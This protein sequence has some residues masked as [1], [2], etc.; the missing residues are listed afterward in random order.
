M[1]L[2]SLWDHTQHLHVLYNVAD[3]RILR[4]SASIRSAFGDCIKTISDLVY[5]DDLLISIAAAKNGVVLP[6]R[7]RLGAGALRWYN[8]SGAVL[9]AGR[10][11]LL[12]AQSITDV[13]RS[14]ESLLCQLNVGTIRTM[15]A[16]DG[17]LIIDASAKWC[18]LTGYSRA[19]VIG[20]RGGQKL[21]YGPHTSASTVLRIRGRIANQLDVDVEAIVSCKDRSTFL[22]RITW[23]PLPNGECCGSISAC[24][25]CVAFRPP[26][27]W[28]VLL[29]DDDLVCRYMW[30]RTMYVIGPDW[31][32]DVA[33]TLEHAT[34]YDL[35]VVRK[36]ILNRNNCGAG[37][38][39]RYSPRAAGA[40][41]LV[42]ISSQPLRVGGNGGRMLSLHRV[43]PKPEA[44]A[45]LLGLEDPTERIKL[46]RQP[47]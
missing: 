43:P 18:D 30:Q 45:I 33:V 41:F 6:H 47:N 14:W 24:S 5:P 37:T 4:R 9:E 3:G 26:R 35:V 12:S 11:R 44:L 17:Y 25:S 8:C 31:T 42:V 39:V 20:R 15:G 13:H 28:H 27:P 34:Q 16:E 21:L 1:S 36:T 40:P 10:V 19:E 2:E 32:V 29:V 38:Q 7:I 23:R 46:R 22:G